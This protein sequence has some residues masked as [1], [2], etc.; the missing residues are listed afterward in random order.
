MVVVYRVTCICM[1]SRLLG[2]GLRGDECV[3]SCKKDGKLNVCGRQGSAVS[4][5]SFGPVFD[6]GWC[7]VVENGWEAVG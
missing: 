2:D 4:V 3:P 7:I 5:C 1:P 6:M